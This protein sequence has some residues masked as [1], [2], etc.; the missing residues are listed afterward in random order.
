VSDPGSTGEHLD[1]G[2]SFEVTWLDDDVVEMRVR[3]DNGRFA[4]TADCYCDHE[5][6]ARLAEALR[7]FPA[8]LGDRREFVVGTFD[9]DYA[10]GGAKLVLRC[11]D[12]VGHVVADVTLR[13]DG[14]SSAGHPETTSLSL[15]IEPA[16][17]DAFVAGLGRIRLDV[18]VTAHLRQ[19]T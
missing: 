9:P 5:D 18:G 10:G 8:S 19:A 15:P 12:M 7:G 16:A 3:A 2:I 6:L 4:G 1:N 14:R 17:I 11:S 13:S